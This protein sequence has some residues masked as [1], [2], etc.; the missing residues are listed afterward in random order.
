MGWKNFIWVEENFWCYNNFIQSL[1]ELPDS[2]L[3]LYCSNNQLQTLPKLPN[4]LVILDCLGNQLTTI[5]DLPGP[6]LMLDCSDNPLIFIVPL[7]SRHSDYQYPDN[8]AK[9]HS[10]ENY[11]K[12]YQQ[13]MIYRYL[14]AFCIFGGVSQSIVEKFYGSFFD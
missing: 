9:L 6:L 8:L 5:T 14:V 7:R 12:Y 2:L 4:R 3:M 11:L 13:Y 1:S 10:E